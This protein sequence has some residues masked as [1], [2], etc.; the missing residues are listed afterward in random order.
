[1]N[2]EELQTAIKKMLELKEPVL[3]PLLA[4][5]LARRVQGIYIVCLVFL[6]LMV[7]FS[8]ISLFTSFSGAIIGLV[9]VVV[10]A[11]VLRMF[12]EFLLSGS[13]NQQ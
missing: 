1:M 13:G 8:L 3:V 5:K 12:C 10:E 11:I 4:P 7:L 9:F 2:K 6:A